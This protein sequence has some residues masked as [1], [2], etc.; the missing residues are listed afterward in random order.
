MTARRRATLLAALALIALAAWQAVRTPIRTDLSVFLPR[1]P[2][3]EQQILIEQLRSGALARVVL[4][5]IEGGTAEMRGEASRALAESLRADPQFPQ[6]A[7]GDG[8]SLQ[9][10][11]ALVF[12]Q[13]YLLSPAV[14]AERFSVDGLRTAIT[15]TIEAVAAPAGMLAASL[16]PRDPTGETLVLIDSLAGAASPHRAAGVWASRDGER[17]LLLVA[18]RAPLID[19]DGQQRA[20]AT[21]ESR[22]A[23]LERPELRLLTSGPAVFAAESRQRIISEAAVLSTLSIALVLILLWLAY[24]SVRT[25]ALGAVPVACGVLA[26]FA[27]VGA[28][29]GFVHGIT[30]AF[31]ATM[32]GE[33]VDYAIYFFVQADGAGDDDA[34]WTQRLWPTVRLGL[35]TSIVGFAALLFSGFPGLAQLGLFAIAGLVAAALVTRY[36]LPLLTPRPFHLRDLSAIGLRLE[37]VAARLRRAR[38]WIA[39]PCIAAAALIA[40]HGSALWQRE[41]IALSPLPPQTRQLDATLRAELGAPDVRW[42]V[43]IPAHDREAALRGAEASAARLAPLVEEGALAHVDTPTRWLPSTATQRLRQAALPAPD[44]LKARLPTAL[45][46]LPLRAEKLQGFVDDVARARDGPL[47][48]SDSFA[49]TSLG[50]ALQSLLVERATPAAGEPAWLALLPLHA[51]AAQPIDVGRVRSALAGA[52]D[53]GMPL[54]LDMKSATDTLYADYLQEA[55]WLAAAAALA[56]VLLLAA[57]LRSATR[58]LRVI[59][60]LAAAVLCVIGGFAAAGVQLSLLH[61][62]GLL[63]VVAV[64]SNYALLFDRR[65]RAE[66]AADPTE[67]RRMLVSVALAAATTAVTFGVLAP[68]ERSGAG[69]DRQHGGARRCAGAGLFSRTGAGARLTMNQTEV[70]VARRPR[71]AARRGRGANAGAVAAGRSNRRRLR[72]RRIHRRTRRAGHRCH[73]HPRCGARRHLRCRSCRC[74]GQGADRDTAS[75][76]PCADLVRR[77]IARRDDSARLCRS[78]SRASSPACSRSHPGQDREVYGATFPRS[79]SPPG[80]RVSAKL[81][82]T[83]SAAC[84][85]GS[86]RARAAGRKC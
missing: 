74:T 66:P 47:L 44:E 54:L 37:V 49:G 7:N 28:G 27:A 62:V 84:G 16:L 68:F 77:H 19:S 38:G 61:L 64:G 22:F 72:A 83:T 26:G 23:A 18:L 14:N 30:L 55:A 52:A 48:T 78:A 80:P 31:G 67:P 85:A 33:A 51:P 69:H 5:A 71:R 56:I 45:A 40:W 1:A 43:A 46:G 4:V 35:A 41:L 50:F 12:E 36:V 10:D 15:A 42:I 53:G 29:F 6:V 58:L 86:A 11:R 73:R 76:A 79:A 34:G 70:R 8:A 65:G 13:R 2:A 75:P 9:A 57:S 60:P 20:L 25:L 32:I 21:L 17:A 39:L 63:L 81:V 82:S 59:V 24:R 3:L